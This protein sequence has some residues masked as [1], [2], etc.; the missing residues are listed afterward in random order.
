[1]YQNN[2]TRG[3]QNYI[4][5]PIQYMNNQM[6]NNNPLYASNI[7]DKNFYQQMML[8]REE[9]MRRIKNISDLGL[10]EKQ[11]IEYVIA[12]IRVEKSDANEIARLFDDEAIKFTKEFIEANWWKE[13]TNAPYKNILKDEDWKKK[14]N[15]KE[16]LIVHKVTDLDKVGLMEDYQK[17]VRLIEKHDGDLKVIFSASK[18]TEYKKAFKFVQKYRDRVKYNPKDYNDLKDYYKKEQKKY[19]REQKRIDEILTRLMDDEIDDRE[20]KQIEADFIKPSKAK[21]NKSSIK[22]HELELDRQIQELINEVGVDVLKELEE[23]SDTE[24]KKGRKIAVKHSKR[25][26]SKSKSDSNEKSKIKIKQDSKARDHGREN[27]STRSGSASHKIR[28]IQNRDATGQNRDS[29]GQNSDSTGQNS[30]STG[31]NSDSTGQNSDSTGQNSD[32]TG[33]NKNKSMNLSP[34]LQEPRMM[35]ENTDKFNKSENI[36]RI[37]IK[38]LTH[39]ENNTPHMTNQDQD[40]NKNSNQGQDQDQVIKRIR[41]ARRT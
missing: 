34:K 4:N 18:E 5:Q 14:F 36:T 17:L 12:P 2:L 16:D 6:F 19:D 1:M 23:D 41:I 10:D 11:M 26:K 32:S 30:D 25:S 37:R 27:N 7:H 33:Q 20:L 21:K 31:Q 28:I 39:E 38:K 15:K 9:Q 22:E 40:T 13:R 35:E 3:Y 24:T 29:T 8:Q